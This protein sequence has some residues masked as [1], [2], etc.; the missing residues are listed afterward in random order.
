MKNVFICYE[1]TTGQSYS[2]HLKKALEKSTTSRYEVFL[3]D[4]TLNG[5]DKWEKKINHALESCDIF[6]VII[7]A[8]TMD[9][10]EVLKEFNKATKLNKVI[11]PIRYSAIEITETFDFSKLQQI[12]FFDKEDLANKAILELKNIEYQQLAYIEKESNENFRRGNLLYNFR[13]FSE[14]LSMYQKVVQQNYNFPGAWANISKIYSIFDKHDKALN[15]VE[16]ALELNPEF[17][18]AW[19]DRGMILIDVDRLL[20]ALESFENAIKFNHKSI[21][22]WSAKGALLGKLERYEEAIQALNIVLNLNQQDY[23]TWVLKGYINVEMN[24]YTDAESDYNTAISIKPDFAEAWYNLSC[25]YSKKN[26]KE[27]AIE[28][29]K[30]AISFNSEFK[31]SFIEDEDFNNF[32]TVED[33]ND[34][35]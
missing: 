12:S 4:I 22:A 10:T 24:Q 31:N 14:A 6:V 3:A 29:L 35:S 28:Y 25:L 30:K 17:S 7:T 20:E 18:D 23:H 11:L 8:L 33:L 5:G 32:L 26:D 16:V 19:I 15:T 13:M 9:S 2:I 34:F 1:S 21:D 27:K